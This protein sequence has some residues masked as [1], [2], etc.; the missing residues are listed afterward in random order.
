L[1]NFEDDTEDT[2]LQIHNQDCSVLSDHDDSDFELDEADLAELDEEED[3]DY[4]PDWDDQDLAIPLEE[5]LDPETSP[6]PE[7]RPDVPDE[8]SEQE[9]PNFIGGIGINTDEYLADAKEN[10][11][12][13]FWQEVFGMLQFLHDKCMEKDWSFNTKIGTG[14]C[15]LRMHN[16]VRRWPSVEFACRIICIHTPRLIQNLLVMEGSCL[17]EKLFWLRMICEHVPELRACNAES[18]GTYLGIFWHPILRLYASYVGSSQMTV[19]F[20]VERGHLRELKRARRTSLRDSVSKSVYNFFRV[21]GWKTRFVLV[22]EYPAP[23]H[24]KQWLHLDETIKMLL[25]EAYD[26]SPERHMPKYDSWELRQWADEQ[27]LSFRNKRCDTSS[28]DHYVDPHHIHSVDRFADSIND[29]TIEG[30]MNEEADAIMIQRLRNVLIECDGPIDVASEVLARDLLLEAGFAAP[31]VGCPGSN[32]EPYDL[33]Q[34]TGRVLTVVNSVIRLNHALPVKQPLMT[35]KDCKPTECAN[36]YCKVRFDQDIK[37][38]P[39]SFGKGIMV[40]AC[41]RCCQYAL[42]CSGKLR[43]KLLCEYGQRWKYYVELKCWNCDLELRP[44]RSTYGDSD[45]VID[46]C[47]IHI[48]CLELKIDLCQNC[49]TCLHNNGHLPYSKKW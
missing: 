19:R 46:G 5:S 41:I 26:T 15:T 25:L 28:T 49:S 39:T 45:A 31:T 6:K 44:A 16:W 9:I 4:D 42:R 14:H 36:P 33:S 24:S 40:F 22:G 17:A 27:Y 23:F 10:S 2:S 35:A 1:G 20:R 48:R 38:C 30:T 12:P 29:D 8:Q 7:G 11:N 32:H 13:T 43:P 21:S 18:K 34:G 3:D 47:G 37:P